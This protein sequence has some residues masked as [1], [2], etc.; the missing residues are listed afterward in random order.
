MALRAGFQRE[1]LH[2]G[3][4]FQIMKQKDKIRIVKRADSFR[5][6]PWRSWFQLGFLLLTIWIGVEFTF[7]VRQ[8]SEGR[9]SFAGRPP[10]VEAFLPISALMSLKY[11]IVTGIFNTI[12]PA[13]LVLLL[14]FLTIA[15]LLKKGFCS[16][17]CPFGLLSEFLADIHRRIFD[18][19]ISLPRWLDYPLRSLKYLLLLFFLW[20]VFFQMDATALKKFI[21]SPYN[22]V[23]DIKMLYFFTHMSEMTFWVLAV[24]VGLSMAIPYFWCRYLCPYGALLGA[25]SWLSPFKVRRNIPTCIDCEKCTQVCPSNISV[26]RARAVVSDEC[27][28]CLKCI[29]ACPVQDTLYLA[30]PVR[31]RI[32]P[33]KAYALG[34]AVIFTVGVLAAKFT[35]FW[36]NSIPEREYIYHM[37]HLDDPQYYHNRGQV[38]DYDD[39]GMQTESGNPHTPGIN[40]E[41]IMKT[42]AGG[43][44]AAKN[45]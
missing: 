21:Y 28:V 11:W 14:I 1:A 39:S 37:Q 7:F 29:D 27:H 41:P 19:Q 34:V 12:H 6:Q 4:K 10:G 30:T 17:I 36:Q 31:K 25:I 38:P 9:I 26:H 32:L 22:R 8:I 3:G 24:L 2:S 18:R 33:R 43:R 35:G 20:A 42:P 40:H 44:P 13:S 5:I 15:L 45:P 16:W 23:A